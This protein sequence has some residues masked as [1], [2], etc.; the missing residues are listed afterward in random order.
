MTD[1]RHL[2]NRRIAIL[3]LGNGSTDLTKFSTMMHNDPLNPLD[4]TKCCLQDR[5]E[6]A[7][8]AGAHWCRLANTTERPCAAAMRPF[9]TLL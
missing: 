2:D 8:V 4:R 9:V 7:K 5:L 3:Y 1:G 6:C